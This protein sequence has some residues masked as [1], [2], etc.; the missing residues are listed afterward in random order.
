MDN[1]STLIDSILIVH[2]TTRS[3]SRSTLAPSLRVKPWCFSR[4]SPL[5]PT[6]SCWV[7]NSWINQSIR[8]LQFS[9]FGDSSLLKVTKNFSLSEFCKSLI[10]FHPPY[11]YDFTTICIITVCLKAP[12]WCINV[13]NSS[14][15]KTTQ[16][17]WVNKLNIPLS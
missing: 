6:S 3:R 16:K 2:P 1:K 14:L 17:I 10:R 11:R 7:G 12:V 13:E 5:F 15:R 9:S 8:S 4:I